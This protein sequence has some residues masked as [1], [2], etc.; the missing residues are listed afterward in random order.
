MIR[1]HKIL[2]YLTLTLESKW[3]GGQQKELEWIKVPRIPY[4]SNPKD[5]CEV[6]WSRN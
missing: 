1:N 4:C 6:S 5:S 3:G 2:F